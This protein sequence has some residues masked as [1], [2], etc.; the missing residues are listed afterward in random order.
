MKNVALF[1]IYL[2]FAWL[3]TSRGLWRL[4]H[5]ADKKPLRNISILIQGKTG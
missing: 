3:K 5:A 2:P 1:L 4:F